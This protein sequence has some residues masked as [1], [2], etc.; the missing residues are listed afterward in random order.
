MKQNKTEYLQMWEQRFEE[1]LQSGMGITEWCKKNNINKSQYY[2]WLRRAHKIDKLA[3]DTPIFADVSAS[4]K[5]SR[6]ELHQH[7]SLVS[8]FQIFLKGIQITVP[9]N[10]SPPA[11]SSLIKVL[12]EL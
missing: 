7:Q 11:L 5:D 12:Q 6:I 3:A 9:S 10:F 2:Y 8:D 1:R 4:I